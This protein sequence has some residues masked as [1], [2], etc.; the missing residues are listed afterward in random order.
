MDLFYM[1]EAR[2]R[3]YML[4]RESE[5]REWQ[6][7]RDK[8]S[9]YQKGI[10]D[11]EKR[12]RPY[13]HS[14]NRL[15]EAGERYNLLKRIKNK[16]EYERGYFEALKLY[17]GG[18]SE[19]YQLRGLAKHEGNKI[20][21][22]PLPP[23]DFENIKRPEGAP[24]EPAQEL[25]SSNKGRRKKKVNIEWTEEDD[26]LIYSAVKKYTRDFTSIP[27]GYNREDV[28][29]EAAQA[30]AKRL[31]TKGGHDPAKGKKSTLLYRV[32]QNTI[33]DLIKAANTD[34]RKIIQHEAKFE[35]IYSEWGRVKTNP[36]G[37]ENMSEQY[38]GGESKKNLGKGD[39]EPTKRGIKDSIKWRREA[40]SDHVEA[41]ESGE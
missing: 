37:F 19:E 18:H 28:L 9:N 6:R 34:K 21:M 26:K 29:Q 16:S 7:K 40:E 8:A 11:G 20:I 35:D 14:V 23:V 13:L 22:E 15:K 38:N 2:T 32:V 10:M 41:Q 24:K 17:L 30:W 5:R 12:Y 25:V 31:M 33:Q 3:Y 36:A 27:G 1:V 4:Q 39:F